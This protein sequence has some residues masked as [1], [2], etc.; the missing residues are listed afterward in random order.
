[1]R[2]RRPPSRPTKPKTGRT[3]ETARL[4]PPKTLEIGLGA[5]ADRVRPE[6]FWPYNQPKR[7]DVKVPRQGWCNESSVAD[8]EYANDTGEVFCSRADAQVQ[9]PRLMDHYKRWG[10]HIVAPSLCENSLA[11]IHGVNALCHPRPSGESLP[12]AE[13]LQAVAI[14]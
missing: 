2:P 14:N 7:R 6:L 8:S 3:G 9:T 10:L 11:L 13:G 5:N 4:T 12:W 1:M